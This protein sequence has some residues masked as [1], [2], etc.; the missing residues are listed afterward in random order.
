MKKIKNIL[1][2]LFIAVIAVSFTKVITG[3]EKVIH[4][5]KTGEVLKGNQVLYYM[6]VVK[7]MFGF[8]DFSVKNLSKKE[9]FYVKLEKY[10]TSK[11]AVS[12]GQRDPNEVVYYKI[13]FFNNNK[14][15]EI[16]ATTNGDLARS[17]LRDGL[18]VNGDLDTLAQARYIL[19][20]GNEYSKRRDAANTTIIQIGN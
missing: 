16:P 17:F 8:G 1:L 19:I 4:N 12:A 10:T 7:L 2:I 15:A 11:Y 13:I 5:T 20:H 6:D 3:E 14:T 9:L 18:I